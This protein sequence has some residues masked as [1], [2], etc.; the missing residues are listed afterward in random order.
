MI[1]WMVLCLTS[2]FWLPT[3]CAQQD[4]KLP[5]GVRMERDLAY[6]PNGDESQ[7][8]DLYLPE[9]AADHPLPLVVHIHGGGW[10]AGSKFPCSF[11]FLVNQGYVVASIEYRFSQKE[12]FPAQ[13]QDCQAAIRWLRAN[14]KQYNI[15]PR[16]IGVIGG[17]AGGHLSALVG[18]SGG[19]QAFPAIGGHEDR[20]DRVQCVCDIFGPTNFATVIKQ[21]EDDPNVRNIFQFNTP[22]DP[23]SSL[24]GES[25]NADRQKTD[26]VSPV[27]F[28]TK[29]TP[30]FLILHGT[31]DAL[32]PYAQSEEL[33][34]DLQAHEVDVW[35]QTLP[36]SGHGGAAFGHPKVIKLIQ[37]FFDRYLKEADVAI[38]LVPESEVAVAPPGRS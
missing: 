25:L 7:R 26:A 6:V 35:L 30:P 34:K 5:A 13:I 32:V 10:R 31:H 3:V 17:S 18:T 29:D 14:A 36:G 12:V 24:I 1:R 27:H 28:V 9:K 2:V 33:V 38:E 20:S 4:V 37:T 22:S 16:H 21:A 15:D 8:L 11:V 19:Q 23:Y